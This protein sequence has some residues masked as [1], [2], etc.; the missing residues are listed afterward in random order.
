MKQKNKQPIINFDT[1]KQTIIKNKTAILAVIY[2]SIFTDIIFIPDSSDL[3]TFAILGIYIASVR[4]YKLK[5]KATYIWCLVLLGIMYLLF[6]LTQASPKTE[7]A[8][9]WLVLFWIIG[10]IQQWRE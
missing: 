7:K 4:L 6:L 3:R 5:S 10:I 2:L 8:A 9:V 1:V